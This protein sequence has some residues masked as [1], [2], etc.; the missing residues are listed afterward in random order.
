[1]ATHL[2]ISK[3]TELYRF[4][5]DCLVCIEA[6]GNYSYATTRDGKRSLICEQLG[7]I[8]EL[9]AQ[10]MGGENSI[11]IR[12]G[13]SLIINKEYIYHID[14]SRKVLVMSDCKGLS[15]ELSASREALIQLKDFVEKSVNP[16]T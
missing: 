2:V 13:R 7:K 14:I 9:I 1:V 3:G 4:P 6:D 8:E 15:K 16:N 5:L 11:F 10:Q 12:I